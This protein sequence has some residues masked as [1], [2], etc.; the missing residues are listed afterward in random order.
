MAYEQ[1]M[2]L[3]SLAQMTPSKVT[4]GETDVV[5]IRQGEAIYALEATCPHSGAPLEKGALCD[6]KLVCPWHKSVFAISES[7]PGSL[8]EPPALRALKRYP[9]K[10][11]HDAVWIDPQPLDE[12]TPLQTADKTPVYV[13]LGTGAGGSAA[14][15]ALRES[16][17]TGRLVVVEREKQAPYD[18]TALSKFVP[19]GD[20]DINEVPS[21]LPEAY[22]QQQQ[23]ERINGNVEEVDSK[24]HSLRLEDGKTL[25][26]HRLLLATGATPQRPDLP[27][28]ALHGVQV[29][30]SLEQAA[31]LV[32]TVEHEHQ[33]VIIGNSFIG[34]E[35]AAALR[36]QDIAVTVVSA[37]PL[38]FEKQFGT[39][40]GTF[41]RR[42]HQEKGVTFVDGEPAALKGIGI[43]TSGR[44]LKS[45]SR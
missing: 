19:Q 27:G 38:P 9:V 40:L 8:L 39:E 17:F 6:G 30:R 25:S 11:D 22:L 18:R 1:V 28:K 24:R 36:K 37:H 34:M 12:A 45:N 2:S 3:S 14:I 16:G 32:A 5:V 31:T 15:K 13:V 33:L 43:Y 29:L 21:L 44:R 41:F 10:V 23:I 35:V 42:R 26:Y 4:V 7:R 20:M